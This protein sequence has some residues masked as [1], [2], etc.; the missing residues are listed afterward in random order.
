MT[1]DEIAFCN[2]RAAGKTKRIPMVPTNFEEINRLCQGGIPADKIAVFI[3]KPN[4][5][6][7]RLYESFGN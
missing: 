3:G 1:T 2:G 5:G 7:S 4:K 6:K